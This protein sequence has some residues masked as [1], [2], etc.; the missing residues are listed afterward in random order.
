MPL[1]RSSAPWHPHS[2]NYHSGSPTPPPLLHSHHTGFNPNVQTPITYVPPPHPS[3]YELMRL[4][5]SD[6]IPFLEPQEEEEQQQQQQ[7]HVRQHSSVNNS[8]KDESVLSNSSP[9]KTNKHRRQKQQL[10]NSRNMISYQDLDRPEEQRDPAVYNRLVPKTG[11]ANSSPSDKTNN[12]YTMKASTDNDQALKLELDRIKKAGAQE[13]EKLKAQRQAVAEK[14]AQMKKN[15]GSKHKI[16]IKSKKKNTMIF[17]LIAKTG[18][19]DKREDGELGDSSDDENSKSTSSSEPKRS[20]KIS[21]NL[22]SQTKKPTGSSQQSTTPPSENPDLSVME[23]TR[24]LKLFHLD[25]EKNNAYREYLTTNFGRVRVHCYKP[26]PNFFSNLSCL[27]EIKRRLRSSLNG[28]SSHFFRHLVDENDQEV[29]VMASVNAEPEDG[30]IE[31]DEENIS[32]EMNGKVLRNKG[33]HHL[34]DDDGDKHRRKRSRIGE[35]GTSELSK[36]SLSEKP[37]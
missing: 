24:P 25:D 36:S 35:D 18:E 21:D 2:N 16:K 15:S 32:R 6:Q 11:K 29:A 19:Q 31:S 34:S 27:E 23:L 1:I 9:S 17:F 37:W 22:I 14:E 12:H 30:E 10:E 33:L 26:Q 3:P 8:N 20:K 13:R 4:A 5:N 28:S 7:Q